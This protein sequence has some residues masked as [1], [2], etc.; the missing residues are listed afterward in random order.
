MPAHTF[1]I[2]GLGF[3]EELFGRLDL[4]GTEHLSWLPPKRAETLAEYADRLA[5]PIRAL[6]EPPALI[7]HSFGGIVA[8][9]IAA[10]HPVRC[11][12]LLSSVKS[13]R[14]IPPALRA[15]APLGLHLLFGTGITLRTFPLWAR[16]F[17]YGA[18]DDRDLF[19]RM[20]ATQS[21]ATLR[22]SLRALSRWKGVDCGATP[23]HHVHGDAD[24]EMARRIAVHFC[25]ALVVIS[26]T[27]SLI[28]IS[29]SGMLGVTSVP[30]TIQ[31]NESASILHGTDSSIKRGCD[32]SIFPVEAEPVKV[33]TSWLFT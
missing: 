30:K 5:A 17:G 2:P 16:A 4:P 25:P 27:T 11:V 29:N 24:L 6:N 1:T 20:V 31:F 28:K 12:V 13:R 10:R 15:S 22:W 23:I 3:T 32:L 7:G 9:E 33:T 26:R 8:Q 19:R 18:A 21:S 14:E